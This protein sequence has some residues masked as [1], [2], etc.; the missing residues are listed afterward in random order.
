[1][2]PTTYE[3]LMEIKKLCEVRAV[4]LDDSVS[5][6]RILGIINNSEPPEEPKL[7]VY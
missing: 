3:A 1:M 2:K 4:K 5:A 7:G 6:H